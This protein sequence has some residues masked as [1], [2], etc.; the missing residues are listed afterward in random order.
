[1]KLTHLQINENL[2]EIISHITPEFP[3]VCCHVEMD[4]YPGG[5]ISWHW[6]EEFE[7]IYVANGCVEYHIKDKIIYLQKGEGFFINSNV[8]HM[9]KPQEHCHDSILFSQTFKPTFLSGSVNNIFYKRYIIPVLKCKQLE[10]YKL[11]R[12]KKSQQKM[13]DYLLNSYLCAEK[14]EWGFEFRIRSMLSEL[15]LD[16]LQDVK[17]ILQSISI[18]SNL[19]NEL[20]KAMMLFVQSNYQNRIMVQ[21]IAEFVNVSERVCFRCFKNT[22]GM[23][24]VEYLLQYRIQ[25]AEELL[26]NT[27]Y[28]ITTIS[29]QVG[30]NNSSYF[31]KMF[32]RHLHCSPKEYRKKNAKN[33]KKE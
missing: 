21:D 24:P 6:H 28:S 15:W 32:Q 9:L 14:E 12:K 13:L 31:T 27:N 30:F 23:T 3:Y 5:F 4:T 10:Y 33:I 7:F 17:H 1:M 20:I 2:E 16:I 22:I 25:A 11:D 26:L 19:E 18:T 29:N 8:L